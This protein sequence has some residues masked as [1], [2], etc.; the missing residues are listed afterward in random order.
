[1]KY[2]NNN[3]WDIRFGLDWKKCVEKSAKT[4]IQ[5]SQRCFLKGN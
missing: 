2:K 4:S 1:M 5:K 3:I